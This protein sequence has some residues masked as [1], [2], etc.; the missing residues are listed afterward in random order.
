M[1][2]TTCAVDTPNIFE[3]KAI[4]FSNVKFAKGISDG[5]VNYIKSNGTF[6]C[7]KPGTYLVTVYI[8]TDTV[9]S[10]FNVLKN[11]EVIAYFSMTTYYQ[12]A[13]VTSVTDLQIDDVISVSLRHEYLRVFGDIESCM[14]IVQLEVIPVGD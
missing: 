1:F 3:G 2:L 7:E 6:T 12:S 8:V 10:S 4:S 11:N 9:R 13:A 5:L 14:S